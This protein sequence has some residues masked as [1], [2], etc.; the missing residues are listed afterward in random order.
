MRYNLNDESYFLV[1]YNLANRPPNPAELFSDGLHHS[2]ARIELGDLRFDSEISNRFS[3][4]YGIQNSKIHLVFD[5]F[6]NSIQDY[7][8]LR[9]VGI[10]QSNRGAFPVWEYEQTNATLFGADVSLR[11][12]ITE[13]FSYLNKTAFIKG[14]DANADLPL[15]DIPAF[16]T[17]N[18]IT[19]NNENWYNFSASLKS[20]WVFEQNEFPDFNF[21]TVNPTTGET[22]L[23]D[24][25]TPPPA[26]NLFHFY[27]EASFALSPKTNLNVAF[28]VN[29]ILNTAYRNYL[30]RLRFFADDLGRNFTLQLQLNY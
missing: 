9:P 7:M 1:N 17:L 15:I 21:E 8:Y 22:V 19:Y 13:Q 24:I 4:T 29:N 3:L 25:S 12:N 23:L 18:S 5:T 11:Y 2:A 10:L 16:S 30:N 27:S 6:Y 20:E 28:G 26:Y 14:Y